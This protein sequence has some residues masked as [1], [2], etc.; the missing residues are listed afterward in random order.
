[1][2]LQNLLFPKQESPERLLPRD[3]AIKQGFIPNA[4]SFG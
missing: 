3:V 2:E 1:M 4:G